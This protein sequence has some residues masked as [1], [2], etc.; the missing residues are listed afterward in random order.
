MKPLLVP[1]LSIFTAM[2]V[3]QS[4]SAAALGDP[5]A[6]LE[7]AEW[8]KG[9]PVDMAADTNKIYVVEF[10][11]TWCPPCRTS[12]P[13][14]TELQKEFKDK[15]VVIIGISDEES[16]VVSK[17]TKRMGDK[18]EYVVALDKE[19][20][21]SNAYMRAYGQGGIPH[22]FIVQR[23]KV[24]WHGHPMAGMD[25]V[26]KEIIS[27]KYDIETAR[28]RMAAQ[29][30]LQKFYEMAM[31]GAEEDELTAMGTKLEALDKEL[32]GI[33]PGETF[34][35]SEVIDMVRFQK[36]VMAYQRAVSA[37]KGQAELDAL[38][39][40][41][42]AVAPREF[43]FDDFKND[44]EL[45]STFS[46]Y[47]R[48]I[49]GNGDTNQIPALTTKLNQLKSKNA[50]VLNDFAWAI[51][52]DDSV[53]VRDFAL[54]T[55]LA[56]AAVDAS[57]ADDPAILDTYARA[58]FDSG[59]TAGAVQWQKK[60]VAAEPDETARNE[61]EATLKDYVAKTSK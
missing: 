31:Q 49:T 44:V 13:H 32:G 52:T 38:G 60:A 27:G 26:L 61:L 16:D 30:Q 11:A 37:G 10:W 29:E 8:I 54:A 39:E 6:P 35:A 4:A 53:K 50:R 43:V 22:A 34:K 36:A 9:G 3:A 47:Y 42:K 59:D 5:A 12:I 19:R 46:A 56:K 21:T 58:L 45:R 55:K 40:K 15:G 25:N 41:I 33:E 51:L 20:K 18:M 24:V 57:H 28:K 2:T 14:L 23:G 17:F 48:A 1:L 7:I